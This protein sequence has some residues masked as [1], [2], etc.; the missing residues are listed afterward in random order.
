MCTFGYLAPLINLSVHNVL[1]LVGLLLLLILL[2]L[3]RKICVL[4]LG[5]RGVLLLGMTAAIVC[6]IAHLA[7]L[8]NL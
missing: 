1:R 7:P 2:L 5:I 3:L 6:K 4:L 8:I